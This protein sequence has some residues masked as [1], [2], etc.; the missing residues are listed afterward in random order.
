MK[1]L[2]I[3]STAERSHYLRRPSLSDAIEEIKGEIKGLRRLLAAVTP[4][5][6]RRARD[7]SV[8]AVKRSTCPQWASCGL[9]RCAGK[10]LL[11][12]FIGRAVDCHPDRHWIVL[13]ACDHR[14]HRLAQQGTE[15]AG[16]VLGDL[17]QVFIAADRVQRRAQAKARRLSGLRPPAHNRLYAGSSP[18]APTNALSCLRRPSTILSKRSISSTSAHLLRLVGTRSAAGAGSPRSLAVLASHCSLVSSGGASII[19]RNIWGLSSSRGWR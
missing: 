16:I 4:A 17:A 6:D 1:R 19:T 5:L 13:I 7:R 14:R 2:W 10:P 15:G 18:A 8:G 9:S 3:S 12:C 11:P